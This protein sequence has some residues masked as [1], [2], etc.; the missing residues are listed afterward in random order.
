M[1]NDG[2]E[3]I[4]VEMKGAYNGDAYQNS[5]YLNPGQNNNWVNITLEGTRANRPAIGARIK[6]NFIENGIRRSVFRM[7]SSG[8]SFGANPLMQHIGIGQ[9]IQ[10]ESIE[11]KWP[12]SNAL[13]YFKNV[14]AGDNIKIREGD[15]SIKKVYLSRLNFARPSL[16]SIGC[17]PY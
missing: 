14:Q 13:Q 10:V 9:S 5:L 11:I 3:D 8:N 6:V 1:D 4:Y 12:G 16:V 7:V 17:A 15:P 2:D